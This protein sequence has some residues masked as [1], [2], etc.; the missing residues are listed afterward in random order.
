MWAAFSLPTLSKRA[1]SW[2]S[3]DRSGAAQANESRIDAVARIG[4]RTPKDFSNYVTHPVN[5]SKQAALQRPKVYNRCIRTDK[6]VESN[7]MSSPTTAA[8]QGCAFFSSLPDRAFSPED[9][10]ADERLM[11]DAAEQ[12]SRKEVLSVQD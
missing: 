7:H 12:F 3:A 10:G 8:P 11:I 9:F 2:G 1:R 4:M 5:R 6:G